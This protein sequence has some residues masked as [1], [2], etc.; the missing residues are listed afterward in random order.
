MK[1]HLTTIGRIR[2]IIIFVHIFYSNFW[3]RIFCFVLF[4]N[5]LN[6]LEEA[7]RSYDL[8]ENGNIDGAM[9][10]AAFLSLNLDLQ[11]PTIDEIYQAFKEKENVFIY[12]KFIYHCQEFLRNSEE[13][14]SSMAIFFICI[15]DDEK[16]K[17]KMLF[18]RNS[19][20]FLAKVL[21]RVK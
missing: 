8:E 3:V 18:L 16:I 11:L 2:H 19:C 13:Q 17:V 14:F 10:Q 6:N 9:F 15:L 1:L 5:I 4:E 12:E 21:G 20:F 7:C